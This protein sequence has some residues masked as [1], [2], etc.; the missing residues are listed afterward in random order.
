[1]AKEMGVTSMTIYRWKK[2]PDM[3]LGRIVD[4]AEYFGMTFEEFLDWEET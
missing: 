3:K 1:M 2:S 4:I